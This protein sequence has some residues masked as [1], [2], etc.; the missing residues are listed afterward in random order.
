MRGSRSDHDLVNWRPQ[1]REKPLQGG[2]I[3]CI[4]CGR[5]PGLQLQRRP[6]EPF[7]VAP[8]KNNIGAGGTGPPCCLETNSRAPA[9]YYHGLPRQFLHYCVGHM[10]YS[11]GFPCITGEDA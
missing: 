10:V 4:E 3:G 9:H 11:W 1:V 6:L 2:G 8:G 7:G 5:S